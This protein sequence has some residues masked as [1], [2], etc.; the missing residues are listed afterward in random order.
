MNAKIRIVTK[1]EQKK[2][3][4]AIAAAAKAELAAEA[5]EVSRLYPAALAFE[6]ARFYDNFV[7]ARR[8]TL[9]AIFNASRPSGG[10]L[11]ECDA[12][13]GARALARAA[14]LLGVL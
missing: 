14:I 10:E 11:D 12:I 8:A 5:A 13:D 1:G 4:P 9:C 2:L 3:A 6:G 7:R